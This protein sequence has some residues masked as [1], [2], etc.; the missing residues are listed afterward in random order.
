MLRAGLRNVLRA[1]LRDVSRADLRN[2]LRADLRNMLRAGPPKYYS[3]LAALARLM[4][5]TRL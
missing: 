2:V 5:L 4:K 1:D 3:A